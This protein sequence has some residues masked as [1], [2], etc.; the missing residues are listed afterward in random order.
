MP[1]RRRRSKNQFAATLEERG[2]ARVF[3]FDEAR[4]GLKVWH[5]RCWCPYGARPPW[6]HEDRYLRLWL[7][8][9]VEPTTGDAVVL[10]L[11]RT[12]SPCLQAFLDALQRHCAPGADEAIA[13]VLDG[14]GSHTGARVH[15]PAGL[16]RVPLPPLSP[17]LNPA[18]R[19]FEELRAALANRVFDTLADL[20]A[21]LVAAL[22]PYW[23]EPKR[24]ISLL[25]YPWWRE[26]VE[27][28]TT[29]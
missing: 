21:A 6:L 11:P 7:Y 12:D 5:R 14:S 15:W 19:W 10:F 29:L 3:A 9:A 28:I 20:E 4:F 8:A 1:P 23:E 18:E 17:E 16:Q 27:H 13:V 25:A 22:R 2:A 26:A 24:L